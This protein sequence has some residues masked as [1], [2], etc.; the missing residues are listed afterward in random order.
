MQIYV[1]IWKHADTVALLRKKDV[2]NMYKLTN[3]AP[4][5]LP[6]SIVIHLEVEQ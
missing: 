5:Y 6:I 4:T 1:L 2:A 3:L